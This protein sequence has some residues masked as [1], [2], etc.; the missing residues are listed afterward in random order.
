MV[1][2]ILGSTHRVPF[3]AEEDEGQ[4]SSQ[5]VNVPLRLFRIHYFLAHD[6][7]I[8]GNL[9]KASGLANFLRENP[10]VVLLAIY[11]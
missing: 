7:P 10:E 11:Y 4:N 8:G 5:N 2:S 9:T 1:Y 6:T 3:S